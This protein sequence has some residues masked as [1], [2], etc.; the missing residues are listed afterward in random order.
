MIFLNIGW[1]KYYQGLGNDKIKGGGAFVKE[2][3][4]GHEIFNFL[5]YK[6]YMYGAVGGTKSIR[7]DRLGTSLKDVSIDGV[8]VIWCSRSPLKGTVVVGW[9]KDATIYQYYQKSPKNSNRK[10]EG[11][12]FGYIIKAKKEDCTLLSIDKRIFEIPRKTGGIG[13]HNVW[14]AD[15]AGNVRLKQKLLEFI[16]KG[17]ISESKPKNGK[18][19]QTNFLK[20]QKVEKAAIYEVKKYYGELNYKVESVEKYNKGWDL[21]ATLNNKLLKLEVKGLS[22][23]EIL[24]ELTPNEYA[25]MQEYKNSYRICVVTNTLDNPS[26]RIFSFS[27]EN[28]EWEDDNG[29]RLKI[30]EKVGARMSI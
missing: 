12:K 6:G 22:Q 19:W 10:Y 28:G 2:S 15:K 8:L 27:P 20:R 7:I 18:S 29:N 25:K 4:Y 30:A 17:R 1:M 14:Y 13:Q 26:L 23:E 24:I 3:G 5:P 16:K 9:Y 21:E 11:E